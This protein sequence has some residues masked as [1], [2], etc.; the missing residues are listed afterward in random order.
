MAS[1]TPESLHRS[2]AFIYL[3]TV[4]AGYVE[5]LSLSSIA[6]VWD[7]R[8]FG[9]VASAMVYPNGSWRNRY[10]DLPKHP[11]Q[12]TQKAV[13]AK[14]LSES[15]LP[16]LFKSLTTGQFATV[17]GITQEIID[18]AIYANKRAWA[19]SSETVF[20]VTL[21]FGGLML[22]A[23]LFAPDVEIYLTDFVPRALQGTIAPETQANSEISSSPPIL[24][25]TDEKFS[26][27]EMKASHVEGPHVAMSA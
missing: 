2:C 15:S 27:L 1:S 24:G 17:P 19:R 21:A 3:G 10:F 4:G 12:P 11:Q 6:L 20:L 7:A 23:S 9:L 5:S 14:G 22:V 25:D 18:A 8:D 13:L 16:A 26:S